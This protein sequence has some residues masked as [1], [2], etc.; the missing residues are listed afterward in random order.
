MF[1][2]TDVR[3][4]LDLT[5]SL[6]IEVWLDGGWAVDAHVG[7]QTRPHNDIDIAL[8][9]SDSLA[10]QSA[11]EL[12]GFVEIDLVHRLPHNFVYGDSD[13]RKIDFHLFEFDGSGDGVY[14]DRGPIYPA[15][16]LVAWGTIADQR[17]RCM[18]APEMLTFHTGYQHDADDAHDVVLLCETFGLGVPEQYR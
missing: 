3:W 11:L 12:Q 7:R 5:R 10:L 13:G 1:T 2:I 16:A 8:Q 17:V 15:A 4:F 18:G 6:G 14:G 9:A